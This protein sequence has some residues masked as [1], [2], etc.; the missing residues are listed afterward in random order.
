MILKNIT[1]Q[2]KPLQHTKVNN[3]RNDFFSKTNTG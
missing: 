2:I 3:N 1:L